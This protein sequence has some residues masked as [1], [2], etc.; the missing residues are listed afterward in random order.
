MTLK[1]AFLDHRLSKM[2]FSKDA[3]RNALKK[4]PFQKYTAC[5]LGIIC[6]VKYLPPQHSC[7]LCLPSLK[8]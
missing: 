3:L 6:L 5:E 4:Y 1:N 7:R 8:M 2:Q